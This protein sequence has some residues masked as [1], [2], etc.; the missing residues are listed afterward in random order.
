MGFSYIFAGFVFLFNPN[1]NIID[2]LPDF[3]GCA[4]IVYGLVKLRDL[5]PDLESARS[6]FILLGAASAAKTVIL[7]MV[8][9]LSDKGFLLVFT[10]VFT[11]IE[12]PLMFTAF[13][14]FFDGTFYAGTLYDAKEMVSKLNGARLTTMIFVFAH[15]LLTLLPEFVYL[16]VDEDI[17]YVLAPYK[18]I[19]NVVA[20]VISCVVG[21]IWL[22][23]MRDYINSIEKD[24][25]FIDNM[26]THY[27]EYIA[28]DYDHFIKRRM[29]TALTFITVGTFFVCDFYIDGV[30]VLP[31][32]I[33][34]LL[35]F[36]G[37]LVIKQYL[38]VWKPQAALS[39]VFA[40]AGGVQWI[41]ERSFADEFYQYGISR[42]LEGLEKFKISVILSAVVSCLTAALFL[43]LFRMMRD[44]AEAH[45]GR[46]EISQFASIREKDEHTRK[47]MKVKTAAFLVFGLTAAASKLA[48]AICLYYFDQY[49]MINLLI[50]VIWIAITSKLTYDTVYAV[51]ERYM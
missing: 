24:K 3:I 44:I 40:A 33:G 18:N 34:G 37:V 41:Y 45:T 47:M 23:V 8:A 49:W 25:H 1:Y 22:S 9:S 50:S 21:A 42:S 14:K 48:S 12:V 31:D 7:F 4:L 36:I 19:L 35:I 26:E 17:G 5:A 38:P 32:L 51:E 27:R 15:G 30:D 16:Y 13:S 20:M 10:F 39:L 2:I 46:R 43:L 6:A 11:I 28:S 29:K